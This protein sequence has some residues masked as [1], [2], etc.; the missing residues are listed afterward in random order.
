MD[1]KNL[2]GYVSGFDPERNI[3]EL[4]GIE[5]RDG[6]RVRHGLLYR[7]STLGNLSDEERAGVDGLG[8]ACIFDLRAAAE[9]DAFPEYIPEGTAHQR[10]AGMYGPDGAEMDFSPAAIA[11]MESS[12]GEPVDI[13]R[14]LYLSMV[15][16]NP[17]LHALVD[18]L[19]THDAPLYFHCS[20]GKDRTGIAAALIL[21]ILG[22]DDGTI[23]RNFLDTNIYR[24]EMISNPPDPLPPMFP[25]KELWVQANEVYP[26]NL[27]AVLDAWGT[28][29]PSREH[30]L[31]E[32]FA[33]DQ[34]TLS[35]LRSFYLH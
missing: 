7:G 35:S 31:Q 25:T 23:I 33:L 11:R 5:A 26:A 21:T 20:A 14:A 34:D 19:K 18:H 17:A 8:L 29:G 32:E 28:Q 27:Q 10:V 12:G 4:G 3:R 2:P 15:R 9:A 1:E 6:R 13:M 16:D 30:F 22:V 24:A